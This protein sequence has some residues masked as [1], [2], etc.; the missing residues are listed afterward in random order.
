MKTPYVSQTRQSDKHTFILAVGNANAVICSTDT[1]K[2]VVISIFL[3]EP[4]QT[5]VLVFITV[6]FMLP[7]I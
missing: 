6:Q 1:T 2:T 7:A 5:A 4:H 3:Q